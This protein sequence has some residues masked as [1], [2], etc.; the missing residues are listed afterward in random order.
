MRLLNRI[1]P[2]DKVRLRQYRGTDISYQVVRV[3]RI[4]VRKDWLL[5]VPTMCVVWLNSS[6][7]WPI[8]SCDLVSGDTDVT[9]E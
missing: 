1:R 9:T 6:S 7:R 3:E 2:G 5:S 4:E 8:E